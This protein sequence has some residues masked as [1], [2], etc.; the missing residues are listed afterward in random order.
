MIVDLQTPRFGWSFR[1]ACRIGLDVSC[2][3]SACIVSQRFSNLPFRKHV[4]VG[5]DKS[6]EHKA[7]WLR[8][9]LIAFATAVI[10]GCSVIPPRVKVEPLAFKHPD[11]IV[12][13]TGGDEGCWIMADRRVFAA[14]AFLNSVGYDEEAQSYEMHPVRI[15]LRGKLAQTLAG[16]S[17]QLRAWKKYY[18]AHL[19]GS[20]KYADFALSLTAD[21]PFRRIR[22]AREVR[23]GQWVA[24]GLRGFPRVLNEFWIVARLESL[25]AELKPEYLAEANRYD[26]PRMGQQSRF[27]WQYL[28]MPRMDH[29]TLI[30]IP[31]PLQRSASASAHQFESYFYS[32]DGPDSGTGALNVHEYLHTFV[33]DLLKTNIGPQKRKLRPYYEAGKDAPISA[34]VRDP[35]GWPTECLVHALD[36][37]IGVLLATNPALKQSIEADVTNLTRGGYTLLEPLYLALADFE[38]SGQPFDVYL[39]TLL[40]NLPDYSSAE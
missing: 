2:A 29:Y 22:P 8:A 28:K 1:N 3:G 19:Y 25:W 21:Y 13:G 9:C 24:A 4:R 38:K 23:E 40:S 18:H 32:V 34:T 14:M 5:R 30:E 35:V 12:K 20:W 16:H 37:R 17:E 27:L 39:P 6:L 31:N 26:L 10:A 7:A 15:K 11:E 36:H 33:N